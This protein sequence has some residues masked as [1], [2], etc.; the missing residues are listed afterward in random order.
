MVTQL[1]NSDSCCLPLYKVNITELWYNGSAQAV[2]YVVAVECFDN[3]RLSLRWLWVKTDNCLYSSG[4]TLQIERACWTDPVM[5]HIL[6]KAASLS[7]IC[8]SSLPHSMKTFS[9]NSPTGES[10]R[11]LTTTE[12]HRAQ[13]A[14][15]LHLALFTKCFLAVTAAICGMEDGNC[16]ACIM[17]TRIV[18]VVKH[19]ERI[20]PPAAVPVINAMQGRRSSADSNHSMG[21]FAK[22]CNANCAIQMCAL[23]KMVKCRNAGNHPSPSRTRNQSYNPNLHA[24]YQ[25]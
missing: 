5:L 25:R 15:I 11:D 20:S 4:R 12:S 23:M 14:L 2:I 13:T 6:E 17:M 16:I 10:S 8:F 3:D 22:R 9:W 18:D 24:F 21:R 19:S 7:R 1:S